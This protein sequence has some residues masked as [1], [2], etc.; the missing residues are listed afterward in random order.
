[1]MWTAVLV[2]TAYA[3]RC[4][5]FRYASTPTSICSTSGD[6]GVGVVLL[7]EAHGTNGGV[8]LS[9]TTLPQYNLIVTEA[10]CVT[11]QSIVHLPILDIHGYDN[12]YLHICMF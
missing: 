6:D 11:T 9:Y 8:Y 5:A 3:V 1:M 12:S 7:D 2:S 10:A 4:K